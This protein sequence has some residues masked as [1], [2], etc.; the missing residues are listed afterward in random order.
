MPCQATKTGMIL[1]EYLETV[2][3]GQPPS[4]FWPERF[5]IITAFNPRRIVTE[6]E[7]TAADF[8][9]LLHLERR[10]IA[11]FRITGCSPDLVHREQGWG[12]L[13]LS[14]QQAVEIGQRHCQNAIF[15]VLDGE[16]F[17]VSCDTLERQS[18]GL[19]QNRLVPPTPSRE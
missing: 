13:D 8:L 1:P 19:F 11:R 6:P 10:R 14:L 5:H 18:L 2:F 15:E 3:L 9:L 17:V 4:R 12:L 7:N 16:A